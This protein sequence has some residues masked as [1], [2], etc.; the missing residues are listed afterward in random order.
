MAAVI[1]NEFGEAGGLHRAALMA[2]GV[3]L[4]A[5]TIIVNIVARAIV[6]RG[7]RRS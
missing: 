6:A 5:L 4:F 3:E 7:L 2:L 1:A